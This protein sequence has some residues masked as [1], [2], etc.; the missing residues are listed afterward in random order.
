MLVFAVVIVKFENQI[1]SKFLINK[2]GE[3]SNSM[4]KTQ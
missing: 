4:V 1:I 2:K 3:C